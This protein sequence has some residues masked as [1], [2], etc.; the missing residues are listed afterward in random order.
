MFSPRQKT[1]TVFSKVAFNYSD[2]DTPLFK[3]FFIYVVRRRTLSNLLFICAH[4]RSSCHRII[5]RVIS[6][7]TLFERD[8]TIFSIEV[9][10]E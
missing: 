4:L 5:R 10:L 7:L 1:R 9:S 8:F 2:H 6:Y 3:V